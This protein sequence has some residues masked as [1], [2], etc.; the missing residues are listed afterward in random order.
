VPFTKRLEANPDKL[1]YQFEI[2]APGLRFTA[3][4]L[5]KDTPQDRAVILE[6]LERD[7]AR[8]YKLAEDAQ[9]PVLSTAIEPG[10]HRICVRTFNPIFKDCSR[11][12]HGL[13]PAV[14]EISLSPIEAKR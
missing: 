12:A 1:V 7:A 2:T 11:P 3:A 10:Q 4:V 8:L 13:L 9:P 14:M 6:R 5:D